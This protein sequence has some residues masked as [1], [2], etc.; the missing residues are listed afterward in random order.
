V[1]TTATPAA[2]P[3][4][5]DGSGGGDVLASHGSGALHALTWFG[6]VAAGGVLV[7]LGLSRASGLRQPHGAIA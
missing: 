3:A 4:P 1:D 7:I 6:L 2:A 5:A